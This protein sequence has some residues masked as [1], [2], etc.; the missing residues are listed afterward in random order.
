MLLAFLALRRR[1][2]GFA[3][4]LGMLAALTL[5]AAV[6][7]GPATT[8]AYLES[9]PASRLP[10]YVYSQG[11]NQSLWATLLRLRG[12][13]G[14]PLAGPARGDM[15]LAGSIVLALTAWAALRRALDE[16]LL[17]ALVLVTGLILYPASLE[18]YSVVLLLPVLVAWAR[19]EVVPGGRV[20]LGTAVV[21]TYALIGMGFAGVFWTYG[22][23][24]AA[25]LVAAAR[26]PRAGPAEA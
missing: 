12:L 25:L 21:I 16:R 22:V 20:A 17:F 14:N 6:A 3:T 7:F 8:A 10:A 5:A 26:R 13:A 2:L 1:W 15:I 11:V 23:L 9:N 18:H 4:A 19:P 24:W